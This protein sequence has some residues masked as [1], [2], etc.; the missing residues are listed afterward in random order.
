M[1]GMVLQ[2][3]LVQLKLGLKVSGKI[4]RIYLK[5]FQSGSELSLQRL[6]LMLK[7]YSLLVEK[8]SLE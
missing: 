4:L 7:M 5:K 8:Y 6:G 3:H 1:L 2:V